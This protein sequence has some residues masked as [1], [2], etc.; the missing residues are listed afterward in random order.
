[1]CVLT[2]GLCTK[3]ANQQ[4]TLFSEL[5]EKYTKKHDKIRQMLSKR[6]LRLASRC[7]RT[8]HW[9]ASQ[10]DTVAPL[11]PYFKTGSYFPDTPRENK[12]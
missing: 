1:M 3:K 9:C 8:Q 5:F 10:A 12:L 7:T 4:D 6:H 2:T 11:Q